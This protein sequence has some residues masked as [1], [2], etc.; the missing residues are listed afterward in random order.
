MWSW[1]RSHFH[2]HHHYCHHHSVPEYGVLGGFGGFVG[3]LIGGAIGANL[4][5]KKER[6][7]KEVI[8]QQQQISPP[9]Q[10]KDKE[11]HIHINQ[12][13]PPNNTA[14]SP[15]VN[16]VN[17]QSGNSAEPSTQHIEAGLASLE[18]LMYLGNIEAARLQLPAFKKWYFTE[19]EKFTDLNLLG[20]YDTR[21][22]TVDMWLVNDA[23]KVVKAPQGPFTENDAKR[24][25]EHLV[26]KDGQQQ[27]VQLFQPTPIMEGDKHKDKGPEEP[28]FLQSLRNAN[29]A[30]R[31]PVSTDP[32]QAYPGLRT[33]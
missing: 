26:T 13:T 20:V 12:Y 21:L 15:A 23:A 25:M 3:G 4:G 7:E 18:K 11:V 29:L 9:Q 16:N 8:V 27:F 2:H 31:N 14:P 17:K 5:R 1:E 24:V 19:R 30:P 10:S 32:M 6:K 33:K 22:L 28:L